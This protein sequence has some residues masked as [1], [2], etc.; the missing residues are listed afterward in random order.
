M[1][2]I[3]DANTSLNGVVYNPQG[4]VVNSDQAVFGGGT[5]GVENVPVAPIQGK[6]IEINCN[7]LSHFVRTAAGATNFLLKNI[8]FFNGGGNLGDS[9][10][11]VILDGPGFLLEGIVTGARANGARPADEA[12]QQ[13]L[14]PYNKLEAVPVELYIAHNGS[15]VTSDGKRCNRHRCGVLTTV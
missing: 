14:R 12:P 11:P 13:T 3:T 10:A 8:A 7:D 1:P 9:F 15:E 6:E 4:A 5:A 2:D